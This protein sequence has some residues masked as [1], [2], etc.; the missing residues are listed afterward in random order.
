MG[1]PECLKLYEGAGMGG[2]ECLNCMKALDGG[3]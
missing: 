3:S 2:T 1:I